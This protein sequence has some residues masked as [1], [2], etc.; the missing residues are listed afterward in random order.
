MY[1]VK[2]LQSV[3]DEVIP[4]LSSSTYLRYNNYEEQKVN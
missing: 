1:I 3:S 4:K 2:V